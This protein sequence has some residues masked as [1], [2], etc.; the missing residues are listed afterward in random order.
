MSEHWWI[1][2]D[3]KAP[4]SGDILE[5]GV[6][7]LAHLVSVLMCKQ[8]DGPWEVR[9]MCT[10]GG[11]IIIRVYEDKRHAVAALSLIARFLRWDEEGDWIDIKEL[12]RRLEEVN[13]A[14][15]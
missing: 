6:V 8:E 9:G 7:N 5:I 1:D 12:R 3:W 15:P 2:I 11:Q 14:R 13:N 4:S 10:H